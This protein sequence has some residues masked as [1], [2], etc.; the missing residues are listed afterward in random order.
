MRSV[1]LWFCRC[2][3]PCLQGTILEDAV[4]RVNI[5]RDT[6]VLKSVQSMLDLRR[7]DSI[8]VHKLLDLLLITIALK[9]QD[10]SGQGL[11]GLLDLVHHNTELLGLVIVSESALLLQVL[12]L[13][14]LAQTV[15]LGD[16]ETDRAESRGKVGHVERRGVGSAGEGSVLEQQSDSVETDNVYV[17]VTFVKKKGRIERLLLEVWRVL[18]LLQQTT[19]K[20]QT[21]HKHKYKHN[22]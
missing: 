20:Q 7:N 17:R 10:P 2:I 6:Q 3:L 9:D 8:A 21:R 15:G 4:T 14:G 18:N 19:N 13:H 22:K 5:N 12:E 16:T 1:L 11:D